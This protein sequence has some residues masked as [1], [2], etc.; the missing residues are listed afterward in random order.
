MRRIAG[1]VL[2]LA[3]VAS[4]IHAQT[5]GADGGSSIY[6]WGKPDTQTY[7]QTVT[8]IGSSLNSFSFWL[9]GGSNLAFQA[10]VFAWDAGLTR[11]TGTSLFSS[12]VLN[13]PGGAGFQQVTINTGGLSVSVGAMYVMFLSTSGVPGSGSI[14]WEANDGNAYADGA[15]VFINNGEN[16]A[17][18]TTQT[19]E[20]NWMAPGRDLRFAATF[21][22]GA[23][24][25]PEPL[26][27]LLLG[28]GL[29]GLGV[30]QR[31]RRTLD[32]GSSPR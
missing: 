25:V 20:T 31:R 17:A 29:M 28:T 14:G 19:W 13:A 6:S 5:V 26:S 24:T 2:A 3:M 15:F 1:S 32:L 27:V 30:V 7:G 10:H 12:A 11:A 4:P 8:A 18:W 21:G 22:E 9:G 23:A 16:Q